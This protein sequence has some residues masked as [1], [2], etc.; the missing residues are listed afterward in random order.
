MEKNL[1]IFLIISDMDADPLPY[2]TPCGAART[3]GV[4]LHG[5]TCTRGDLPLVLTTPHGIQY[6]RGFIVVRY[7]HI[8]L[9]LFERYQS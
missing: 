2:R 6:D 8:N 5:R 9:L 7:R 3:N 4:L 1:L